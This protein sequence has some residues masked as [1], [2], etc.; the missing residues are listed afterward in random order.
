MT[1]R[2]W[3]EEGGPG[4]GPS[5]R[6]GCRLL[7][8]RLVVRLGRDARLSSANV[9]LPAAAQVDAVSP[10]V[11]DSLPGSPPAGHAPWSVEGRAFG[12]CCFAGKLRSP[13]PP[14]GDATYPARLEGG[15]PTLVSTLVPTLIS[16]RAGC[17][18]LASVAEG[19]CPAQDPEGGQ[20][21]AK[22]AADWPPLGEWCGRTER[23]ASRD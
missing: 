1:F 3:S 2:S 14:A 5:P 23:C 20:S 22:T 8:P 17:V 10:F 16:T 21:A 9:R 19:I 4:G 6:P 13:A 7:A 18:P 12:A 11:L 15:S